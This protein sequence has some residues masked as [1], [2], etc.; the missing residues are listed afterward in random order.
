VCEYING[1]IVSIYTIHSAKIGFVLSL[2]AIGIID[3]YILQSYSTELAVT[4]GTALISASVYEYRRKQSD[5][6]TAYSY[7]NQ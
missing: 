2:F 5:I 1:P 6:R 3:V 7:E 4:V